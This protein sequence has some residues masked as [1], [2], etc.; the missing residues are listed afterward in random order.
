[1]NEQ[2]EEW[3][4][5]TTL[6]SR[7]KEQTEIRSGRWRH[8]EYSRVPGHATLTIEGP[9]KPGRAPTD[10]ILDPRDVD[11]FSGRED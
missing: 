10:D 5:V 2:D 1:M 6:G 7:Y 3:I 11:R 9:W 4:D 8:Q